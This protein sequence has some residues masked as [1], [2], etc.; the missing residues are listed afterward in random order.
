MST[1]VTAPN[2][3]WTLCILFLATKNLETKWIFQ[4]LSHSGRVIH[5]VGKIQIFYHA[6]Y[7]KLVKNL[8][9][10]FEYGWLTFKKYYTQFYHKIICKAFSV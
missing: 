6:C 1:K 8:E 2:N 10:P 9:E 7:L 4:M 5:E 3:D